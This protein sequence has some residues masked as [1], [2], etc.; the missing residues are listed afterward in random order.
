M[1]EVDEEEEEVEEEDFYLKKTSD[2][3]RFAPF[4]RFT[5]VPFAKMQVLKSIKLESLSLC[6]SSDL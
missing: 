6:M 3:S 5:L 1:V 4:P 2:N